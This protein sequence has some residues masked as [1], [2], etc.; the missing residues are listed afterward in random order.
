MQYTKIF[1]M[2]Q[3]KIVPREKFIAINAYISTNEQPD[4]TT[5]RTRKKDK[6]SPKLVEKKKQQKSEYK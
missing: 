4:F 1:E 6:L 2:W 3:K 5:Q